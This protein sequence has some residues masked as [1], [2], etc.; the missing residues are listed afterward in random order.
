M[1]AQ[2]LERSQARESNL[3]LGNRGSDRVKES[4]PQGQKNDPE[5]LVLIKT[6]VR[7]GEI[8]GSIISVDN[9]DC[10]FVGIQKVIEGVASTEGSAGIT[11]VGDYKDCG[12]SVVEGAGSICV[13]SSKVLLFV[14][15]GRF[16]GG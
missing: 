9:R 4:N 15:R 1:R 6:V 3:D 10:G 2:L 14:Q 7:K 16:R 11:S 5:G 13:V 8:S 12:I